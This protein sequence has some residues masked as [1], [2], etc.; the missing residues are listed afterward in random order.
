[1]VLRKTCVALLVTALMSLSIVSCGGPHA[2]ETPQPRTAR[3]QATGDRPKVIVLLV[4]SLLSSSIDRLLAANKL[5]ALRF[6]IENGVY[7]RDVISSFPTMSLTVDTEFPD[8]SGIIPR[9]SGSS[10]TATARVS[11][12]STVPGNC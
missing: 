10:T 4:D 12:G 6:L 3:L 1:M 5:P 9:K 11:C 7:K 8:C 2:D